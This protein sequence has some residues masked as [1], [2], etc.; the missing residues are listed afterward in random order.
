MQMTLVYV[1]PI[2]NLRSEKILGMVQTGKASARDALMSLKPGMARAP[3]LN[4]QNPNLS[5]KKEA[6]RSAPLV[7]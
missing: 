6:H 3:R 1:M 2:V 7:S 5:E 4:R